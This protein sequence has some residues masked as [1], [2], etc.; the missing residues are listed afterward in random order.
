MRGLDEVLALD[1]PLIGVDVE[2]TS[3]N[4]EKAHVVQ[5]G[6]VIMR[7]GQPVKEY[8]TLINPGVPIP[9]ASTAVH[10]IT[11]DMVRDAPT[12]KQLAK[13]LE[14]G[15]K[16]ADFAGTNVRFDLRV[17]IAEF[18]R[19]DITWAPVGARILD[20]Y[21]FWQILEP[22]SLEDSVAKWC[23]EDMAGAEAHDALW[24]A[25][26]S[27]R[28]IAQQILQSGGKLPSTVQALHDLANAGFLD[29]E[30]KLRWIEG[31]YRFSFGKHKGDPLREVPVGYLKFILKGDFS[32]DLKAVCR[33]ALSG[34]YPAPPAVPVESTDD[35]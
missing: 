9:A 12:F 28:V 32:E 13:N 26:S 23:P 30:G 29:W 16:G 25:R 14:M 33:A 1:K 2:T 34:N 3:N 4:P 10:H 20:S 6:L 21:R 15:F 31:E 8:K 35:T 27:T 22:R 17:L 24:D 11:D 7:P 5:L 18:K 19:A